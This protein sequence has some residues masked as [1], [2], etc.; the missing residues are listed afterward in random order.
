MYRDWNVNKD[1]QSSKSLFCISFE[2][3]RIMKKGLKQ[4]TSP[5]TDKTHCLNIKVTP[6]PYKGSRLLYYKYL[7]QQ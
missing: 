5:A 2:Y 3:W 7:Q 1:F 4:E 6:S